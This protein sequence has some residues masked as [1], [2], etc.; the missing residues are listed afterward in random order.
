MSSQPLLLPSAEPT[1][2]RRLAARTRVLMEM[3]RVKCQ[4]LGDVQSGPLRGSLVGGEVCPSS[5]ASPAGSLWSNKVPPPVTTPSSLHPGH[6]AFLLPGEVMFSWHQA[7]RD[8][9]ALALWPKS[10]THHLQSLIQLAFSEYL[11]TTHCSRG[12]GCKS[13]RRRSFLIELMF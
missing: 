11:C 4:V 3:G 10:W 13:E 7:I 5:A 2:E 6:Q 9:L 12:Q 8:P 1:R